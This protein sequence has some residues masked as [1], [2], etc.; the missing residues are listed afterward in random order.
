MSK[1]LENTLKQ[2]LSTSHI[3]NI[4]PTADNCSSLFFNIGKSKSRTPGRKKGEDLKAL[5]DQIQIFIT[6]GR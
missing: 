6:S 1:I 3:F 4:W 5:S 2:I